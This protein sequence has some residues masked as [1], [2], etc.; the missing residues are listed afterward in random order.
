MNNDKQE[1]L[2]DR[3]RYN[4]INFRDLLFNVKCEK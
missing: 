4:G 3:S 1:S 2:F